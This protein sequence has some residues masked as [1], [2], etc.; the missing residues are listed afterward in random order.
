MQNEKLKGRGMLLAG[1]AAFAVMTLMISAVAF[2][3]TDQLAEAETA[4]SAV[5]RK[6]LY[7]T[8]EYAEAMAVDLNK[9]TVAGGSAQLALLSDV[10]RQSQGAQANI[11]L[12]P[13]GAASTAQAMKYI[14]QAGDFAAVML[15]RIAAGGSITQDEYA[16]VASLSRTAAQLSL[17]LS[18][19]LEKHE[20]GEIV[21]GNAVDGL[22]A[23]MFADPVVEYPTLLYDGPF[24]DGAQGTEFRALEG[25]RE[26]SAEEAAALL[27]E[28]MGAENVSGMKAD[29]ESVLGTPCY[30]FS[31]SASGHDMTAAVTRTGGKVLY[32]L[33][34]GDVGERRLT[35]A[36]C[37]D[38]AREF[39]LSRGYGDM[40]VSYFATH[41]NVMTVNFAA[42][43]NGVIFYPDLVKLQVSLADG[44]VIGLEAG[45][46]LRN[47]AQRV[48]E[49]PAV[50]EEEARMAVGS[51]LDIESVRL[52]V[53][54]FGNGE[55]YCYEISA[56]N[57]SDT[58]LVYIDAMT[59]A[60]IEIM[61]VVSDDESTLV[62]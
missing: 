47:H 41:G 61:Q 48:L 32:V 30:E 58:Y 44:A 3:R 42:S 29:G 10:I 1:A 5:Y 9:V 36:E 53:I 56:S 51:R 23:D 43:R 11:A 18:S 14:N 39:L 21:L 40:E 6:A 13:L 55:R 7:E 57:T 4:L 50:T 24:S 19:L 45:N 35:D 33:S 54:P 52:C 25:L 2:I 12:L 49:I 60:E 20:A 34:E 38:I 17:S 46:Y 62:M 37:F 8:C 31:F 16:D 22:P 26:V 28:F 27:T 59:G 15:E